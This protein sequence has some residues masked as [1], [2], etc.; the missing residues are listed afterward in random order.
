MVFSIFCFLIDLWP[1]FYDNFGAVMPGRFELFDK[2]R[3]P[4]H[5]LRVRAC[6]AA[7]FTIEAKV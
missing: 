4:S 1:G 5:L 2:L 6:S 7:G 3:F